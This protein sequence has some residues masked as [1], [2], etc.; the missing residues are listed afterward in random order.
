MTS[1]PSKTAQPAMSWELG[2]AVVL[3]EGVGEVPASVIGHRGGIAV[4]AC[5]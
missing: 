3:V 2:T 4:R 1:S 5:G